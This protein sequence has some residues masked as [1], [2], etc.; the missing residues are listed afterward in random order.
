MI[1]VFTDVH[2]MRSSGRQEAG[3]MQGLHDVTRAV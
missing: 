3:P 2:S 1:A